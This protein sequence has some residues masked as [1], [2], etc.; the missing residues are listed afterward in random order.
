MFSSPRISLTFSAALSLND[1]IGDSPSGAW[2]PSLISV[3]VPATDIES[4]LSVGKYSGRGG[5]C[6]P[7]FR[8]LE[9]LN[10]NSRRWQAWPDLQKSHG[11]ASHRFAIGTPGHRGALCS[12]ATPH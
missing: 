1:T 5:G 6:Q 7:A 2:A 4:P 11:W 12:S 8:V 3:S 10:P 9:P